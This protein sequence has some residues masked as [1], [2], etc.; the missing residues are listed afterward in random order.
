MVKRNTA[1]LTKLLAKRGIDRI[2]DLTPE[3]SAVFQR[4]KAV[5]T[6]ENVTVNSLKEFCLSQIR[7]IE[8]RCDGVNPLTNLQQA[9]MH[10]YINLLK[11]I[12]AP[13]SERESLEMHLNQMLH[14]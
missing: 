6:G 4:Y 11:A 2:E 14:E 1:V 13:E 8:A 3:E 12:E 9:S 10:V 5:L 7:I